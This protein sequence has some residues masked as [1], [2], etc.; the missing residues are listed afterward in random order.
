MTD[1]LP[2]SPLTATE[3]RDRVR[4]HAFMA[5]GALTAWADGPRF[6]PEPTVALDHARKVIA[7]QDAGEVDR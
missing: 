2:F 1:A 4:S 6:D 3:I 7:Y 5:V